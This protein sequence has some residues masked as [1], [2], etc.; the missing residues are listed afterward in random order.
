M[1]SLAEKLLHSI[2][3]QHAYFLEGQEDVVFF[4]I[5]LDGPEHRLIPSVRTANRGKSFVFSDISPLESHFYSDLLLSLFETDEV[6]PLN[7]HYDRYDQC[8]VPLCIYGVPVSG[9]IVDRLTLESPSFLNLYSYCQ[10]NLL[11]LFFDDLTEWGEA[12]QHK[13][14]SPP[15]NGYQHLIHKIAASLLASEYQLTHRQG[16]PLLVKLNDWHGLYVKDVEISFE[17]GQNL[18]LKIPALSQ[19]FLSQEFQNKFPYKTIYEPFTHRML[20]ILLRSEAQATQEIT[21]KLI[22]HYLTTALHA[23][24]DAISSFTEMSKEF[25]AKL[26]ILSSGISTSVEPYEFYK[27]AAGWMI[28]WDSLRV[29]LGKKRP[30]TGLAY[31]HKLLCNEDEPIPI[32]KLE[33]MVEENLMILDDSIQ[34]VINKHSILGN[35]DPEDEDTLLSAYSRFASENLPDDY[36]PIIDQIR[37]YSN[38]IYL[39]DRL[40]RLTIK[41]IYLSQLATLRE[42]LDDLLF[43]F[44]QQERDV[45]II[46]H[47]IMESNVIKKS[48]DIDSQRRQMRDR[49]SKNIKN[50]IE[51]MKNEDIK[52]FLSSY[53]EKGLYC[54][55]SPPSNKKI[56]WKLFSD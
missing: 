35:L 4:E 38:L 36:S 33:G 18:L 40:F 7:N 13:G 51:S 54:S 31:I 14:N 10:D 48:D 42:K 6:N 47:V 16:E 34:I 49:V 17:N 55:Y 24:K 11:L 20:S 9:F 30:E 43:I 41:K 45:D 32:Y 5:I 8:I 15:Q 25:S 52:A 46:Q 22:S 28:R 19:I 37:Y 39:K 56:S 2:S 29:D 12:S 53:I 3:K 50:A 23:I 26:P 27:L 1:P 21:E 44:K